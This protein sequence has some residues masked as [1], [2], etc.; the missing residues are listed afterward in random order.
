MPGRRSWLREVGLRFF[1]WL[2]L[3]GWI[4]SWVT[5]GALVAPTA[6]RALPSSELAGQVVGPVISTLHGYGAA[7]GL[8]LALLAWSLRRGALLVALP[9]AA[10]AACAWSEL[11]ITPGIAAIRP[12]MVGPGGTP[13]I[14]ARFAHLHRVSVV[15]FLSVGVSTLVMLAAHV[16]A[17]ARRDEGE[18]P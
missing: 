3:G 10:A 4:G 17:D 11:V 7:A 16:L 15:I 2:L 6:F 18:L 9:L 8:L 14:A 1:L 5:F 12:L 13:E